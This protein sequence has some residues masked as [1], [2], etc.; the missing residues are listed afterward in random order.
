MSK[1][2]PPTYP[3]ATPPTMKGT[4]PWPPHLSSWGSPSAP[5]TLFSSSSSNVSTG[6]VVGRAIAGVVLNTDTT[7]ATSSLHLL[8]EEEKKM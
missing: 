4:T 7:G 1:S 3:F 5:G 8:Q 6:L 2:L